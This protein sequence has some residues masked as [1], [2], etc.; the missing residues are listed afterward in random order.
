VRALGALRR[1]P[2]AR[3]IAGAHDASQG[4]AGTFVR[5]RRNTHVAP[6]RTQENEAMNKAL[7]LA[8]PLAALV[9]ACATRTPTPNAQVAAAGSAQYCKKDRLATEGDTLTCT[10]SPTLSD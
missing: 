5:P 7:I 4:R 9:T 8:I 10:W 1:L 3:G 2:L 6:D